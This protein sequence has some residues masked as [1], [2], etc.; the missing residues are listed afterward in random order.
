M[1]IDRIEILGIIK[2]GQVQKQ[3]WK[4]IQIDILLGIRRYRLDISTMVPPSTNLES[5][6][7]NINC[8]S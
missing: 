6:G 8:R 2:D 5:Y 4:S 7:E 3:R 1:F